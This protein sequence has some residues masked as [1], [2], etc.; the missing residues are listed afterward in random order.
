MIDKNDVKKKIDSII[1]LCKAKKMP[2]G[3]NPELNLALDHILRD[4]IWLRIDLN[5]V[6]LTGPNYD[7]TMGTP[8]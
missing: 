3:M 2:V 8:I 5:P 7:E 4:L 6:P 1:D